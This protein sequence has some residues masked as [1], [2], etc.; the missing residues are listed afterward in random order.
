MVMKGPHS[1][2]QQPALASC[3]AFGTW[4][5]WLLCRSAR[6]LYAGCDDAAFVAIEVLIY[7]SDITA[8]ITT[9]EPRQTISAFSNHG[10]LAF[11]PKNGTRDCGANNE[12]DGAKLPAI[13][14]AFRDCNFTG[15]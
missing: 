1:Q 12:P 5:G 6:Y 3:G 8:I 7:W 2:W 9:L 13:W 15:C 10:L 14:R 4:Y 11:P